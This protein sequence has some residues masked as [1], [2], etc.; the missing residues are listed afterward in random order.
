MAYKIGIGLKANTSEQTQYEH[1]ALKIY[2]LPV[3]IDCCRRLIRYV[4]AP[5]KL[6]TALITS[7]VLIVVTLKTQFADTLL[8]CLPHLI[9][10][11]AIGIE[12]L[13]SSKTVSHISC[14]DLDVET[15]IT[16]I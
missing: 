10:Q 12:N 14:Y 1:R 7:I 9:L 6:Y 11:G 16:F 2:K 3:N 15:L 13:L 5:N 4:K 8:I